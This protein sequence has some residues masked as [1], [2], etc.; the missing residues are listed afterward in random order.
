MQEFVELETDPALESFWK[1]MVVLLDVQAEE[2][3]VDPK[4]FRS[5]VS[6][7][8]QADVEAMFASKSPQELQ[9]LSVQIEDKLDRGGPIDVDYWTSVLQELVLWKAKLVV[10][11]T[12]D[13]F[14]KDKFPAFER[15]LQVNKETKFDPKALTEQDFLNEAS[16]DMQE[17]ENIF[18]GD[19]I[20]TQKSHSWMEKYVP[21]KPKYLNRIHTGFEWNNYNQVHYNANN[22]PPKVKVLI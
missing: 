10:K 13:T 4:Q 21:R 19:P 3:K 8:V 22:P 11:Q 9:S 12:Y 15:V 18:T 5:G 1:E 2:R 20:Q 17:D 7:T 6:A 16:K 14:L